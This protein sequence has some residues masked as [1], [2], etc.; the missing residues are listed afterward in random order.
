MEFDRINSQNEFIYC[1]D[2]FEFE[3]VLKNHVKDLSAEYI[4][5]RIL[6]ESAHFNTAVQLGY[7]PRYEVLR[8][9]WGKQLIDTFVYVGGESL[10]DKILIAMA[11]ENPSPGD[12]QQAQLAYSRLQQLEKNKSF[13]QKITGKLN[14][15]YKR[16]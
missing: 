7:S 9:P 5:D 2:I 6:H 1:Y 3:Y 13:I 12:L 8:D 4:F 11:P 14:G 15:M 10:E 16:T